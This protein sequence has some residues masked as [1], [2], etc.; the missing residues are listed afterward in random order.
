MQLPYLLFWRFLSYFSKEELLTS[1]LMGEWKPEGCRQHHHPC[2]MELLC[3]GA[4]QETETWGSQIGACLSSIEHEWLSWR[5]QEMMV[6]LLQSRAVTQIQ[7]SSTEPPQLSVTAAAPPG[8]S[9]H[10]PQP[11]CLGLGKGFYMGPNSFHA[12]GS[13]DEH[14]PDSSVWIFF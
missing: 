3:Y 5:G 2:D 7:M 6:T 13:E 12:C 1:S 8:S 10:V 14:N 11:G 9:W 4:I